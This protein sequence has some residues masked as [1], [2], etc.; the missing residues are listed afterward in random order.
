MPRQRCPD[1]LKKERGSES[2]SR[3]GGRRGGMFGSGPTATSGRSS[4]SSFGMKE[5]R[6]LDVLAEL[7]DAVLQG[8]RVKR[9]MGDGAIL[10]GVGPPRHVE[11]ER[12]AGPGHVHS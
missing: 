5:V 11:V 7:P 4:S 1:T 12:L 2:R 8:S 10:Q 6:K 9:T 3:L